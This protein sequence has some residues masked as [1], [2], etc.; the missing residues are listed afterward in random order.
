MV[1][2]PQRYHSQN[3][4]RHGRKKTNKGRCY[5]FE[6]KVGQMIALRTA[7]AKKAP[8]LNGHHPLKKG[9]VKKPSKAVRE[10][11]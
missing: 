6:I 5:C 2:G 1:Q 4:E 9:V 3:Q 10:P 7:F 11:L 8:K